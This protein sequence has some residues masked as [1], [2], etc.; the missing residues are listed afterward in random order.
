ME[1]VAISSIPPSSESRERNPKSAVVV[2][3][4]EKHLSGVIQQRKE[5]LMTSCGLDSSFFEPDYTHSGI[6]LAESHNSTKKGVL[7]ETDYST[8]DS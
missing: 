7:F 3:A 4:K 6:D 2:E 1:S 5:A 8:Y